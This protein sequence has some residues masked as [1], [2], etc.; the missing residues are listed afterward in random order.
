MAK[1]QWAKFP[2]LWLKPPPAS[3]VGS[4]P[5]SPLTEL[6]WT[7]HAGSAIA[8]IL[9]LMALAIRLNQSHKDKTFDRTTVRGTTIA[10][11]FEELRKMTGLAKA[12]ISKALMLLESFQAIETVREG[13][14]NNY[15]LLGL[16]V[17]GGWCML[18]HGWLLKGDGTLR[19]FTKLPRNRNTL[20]ALKAYL[21]LMHLRNNTLNTAAVSYTAIER[22]TAIRREDIPTALSTL[23]ALQLVKVSPDRDFRHSKGDNSHRYSIIG[24]GD[25]YALASDPDLVSVQKTPTETIITTPVERDVIPGNAILSQPITYDV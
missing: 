21:V 5:R 8:V 16:D 12:S 19:A 2:T 25:G 18:P 20:N 13:R 3:T 17:S 14:S 1:L 24:L 9:V 22:W 7:P 15:K 11:T 23:A 10:V 6:L 4:T